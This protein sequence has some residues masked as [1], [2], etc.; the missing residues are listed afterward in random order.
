MV[1]GGQCAVA[2]GIVNSVEFACRLSDKVSSALGI[3]VKKTSM[4]GFFCIGNAAINLI[5]PVIMIVEAVSK[6]MK[7]IDKKL[8]IFIYQYDRIRSVKS[9][10]QKTFGLYFWIYL[11][12]K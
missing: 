1:T 9:N 4:P 5:M 10:R 8:L 3:D 11:L 2:R 6:T 12:I 7:N